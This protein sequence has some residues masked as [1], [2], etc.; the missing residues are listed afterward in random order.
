M[1]ITGSEPNRP[2][3]P[4]TGPGLPPQPA[5]DGHGGEQQDSEHHAAVAAQSSFPSS[6]APGIPE[7]A[8]G[9]AGHWA[10]RARECHGPA[11]P[12]VTSLLRTVILDGLEAGRRG[13]TVGN[14]CANDSK[15]V[16]MSTSA[17]NRW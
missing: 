10:G 12:F 16:A 8:L 13:C 11:R 6:A 9:K 5:A 15:A 1:V 14:S 17:Q 2:V 3:T 7:R 4:G